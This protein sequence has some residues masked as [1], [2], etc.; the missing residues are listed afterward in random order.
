M[1]AYGLDG[2]WLPKATAL[3]F[4]I[5][6]SDRD[7]E[8][9]LARTELMSFIRQRG[10]T[11]DA[12][13]R[14]EER[15]KQQPDHEPT[16]FILVDVYGRLKDDPKR[17][18]QALEQINK[19]KQKDGGELDVR[20][21]AKLAG[22][23]VKAKKFKE[24]AELFEKT[25]GRDAALAAWNLKEAAAAWLKAGDKAS[26]LRAARESAAAQPEKRGALLEYFWHRGLAD[27][28]LDAGEPGLAVPHYEQA[29]AKTTI[30]GYKK[31]SE[32][33]LEQAKAQS[34]P[35]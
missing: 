16:L 6:K 31:D 34:Q 28:F 9:S 1:P 26:A 18:A 17:S 20:E 11:E 25:A 8:R 22:E 30:D 10:K 21:S 15:L 24:G 7:A 23:Y 33:R 19:L 29:I 4:I 12:V 3:E 27:V 32:K 5:E 13:K 35:K 14:Y 2:D